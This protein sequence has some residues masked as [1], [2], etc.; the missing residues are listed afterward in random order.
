MEKSGSSGKLQFSYTLTEKEIYDG[1]R[2]SG[3]YRT[4]GKRA[5]VETVILAVFCLFFFISYL[6]Q[7]ELFNLVMTFVSLGVLLLLNLVPRLDMRK[8]AKSCHRE[9]KLR[10]YPDRFIL[11]TE[12]GSQSVLLDGTSEIRAVGKKDGK[13]LI[14][15]IAGGGLL[16]IPLRA[17]PEG[18]R[19]QALSFLLQGD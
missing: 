4:S 15:R 9:V 14:V 3:V 19:G 8:Q 10:L 6:F 7:K 5:I 11:E 17:I 2:L 16:V 12:A 18:M 1:L 13:L